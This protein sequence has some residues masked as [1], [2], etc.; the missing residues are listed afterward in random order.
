MEKGNKKQLERIRKFG[1]V[2]TPEKTVEN[3]LN[4]NKDEFT[5]FDARVL[6]PACGDGNFLLPILLLRISRVNKLF[7]NNKLEYEKALFKSISSIYGV[8]ILKDNVEKCTLRL[9]D[10]CKKIYKKTFKDNTDSEFLNVLK[11]VLEKNIIQGDALK[12]TN[13]NGEPLFFFEWVML[14]KGNVK[15]RKYEFFEIADFDQSRPT[16][17]SKLEVNDLGEKVFSPH[18]S[19]EYD[20]IYFK[21]ITPDF[22]KN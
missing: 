20:L 13:E 16:L 21:N 12:F 17:F 10:T 9:Y 5:R 15:I 14:R 18:P 4:L 3:M 7:R 22:F 8:D 2:F 19:D 1:E 11:V 6:E